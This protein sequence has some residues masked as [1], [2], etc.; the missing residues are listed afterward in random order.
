MS[1]DQQVWRQK[2]FWN[3]Q[4]NTWC[5]FIGANSYGWSINQS[6]SF[7]HIERINRNPSWQSH[8][9]DEQKKVSADYF[10]HS[11]GKW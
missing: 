5:C 7:I 9:M 6:I 4:S 2:V 1:E 3:C 8:N 11:A 10:F